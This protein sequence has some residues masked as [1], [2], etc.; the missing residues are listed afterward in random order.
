MAE[1]F[2]NTT[3]PVVA[4]DHYRIPPL[5]RL[6]LDEVLRLVDAKRYCCLPHPAGRA[7]GA[8]SGW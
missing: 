3:G 8:R 7:P 6:H 5:G 1:R 4:E 2:F